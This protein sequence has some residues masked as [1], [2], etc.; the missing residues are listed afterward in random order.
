[1]DDEPLR[2]AL[3][4]NDGRAEREIAEVRDAVGAEAVLA[5]T[6]AGVT[7]QSVG[8]KLRWLARHEPE[9]AAR[10]PPAAR[11]AGR[12]VR[13]PAA[14]PRWGERTGAL[15]SG[16]SDRERADF[17]DDLLAAAGW[18]RDR[19]APIRAPADVVGGVAA[20]T[21][22]V[23]GLRPGVPVVAGMADHVASAF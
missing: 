14:P 12:R 1:A 5:R 16:L 10:A 15:G 20:A 6:G 18:P 19:L 21:A 3:L 8:P 9:L 13:G 4:Y 11:P 7:Q 22:E 23:T 2:P 17:A